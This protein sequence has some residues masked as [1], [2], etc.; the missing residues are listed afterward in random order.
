MPSQVTIVWRI[1]ARFGL[2]DLLGLM[3]KYNALVKPP[4]S[5][6]EIRVWQVDNLT[7]KY[8][9][10]S[11]VVQGNIN[12]YTKYLLQDIENIDGLIL[13]EKNAAKLARIF[14]ARQNA[15]IC[16]RC[17]ETSLL[18]QAE[19]KGLDIVF[20]K[21]CGHKNALKPP[22]MM[23]CA[24]I[25]PDINLL[26]SK[27]MSRLLRLGLLTDF[28]I[29]IPEFIFDWLDKFKST[30][31]K[32]AISDELKQL[33][34]LEQDGNVKLLPITTQILSQ[35]TLKDEDQVILAISMLTNSILL[36]GD[37]ILKDRALMQKRP[38]I[39]LPPKLFDQL[40]LLEAVR[41]PRV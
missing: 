37:K 12:D 13:D 11:L 17:R 40:K 22:L 24:R 14:P 7:V 6:H 25:L 39:Y 5:E 1:S 15:I 9:Q 18:I 8:Y 35:T 30:K 26:I 20:K 28:E 41:F 10:S 19:K 4:S 16:E 36:T 23:L 38:V 2:E 32:S 3:E 34:K 33:R 21:E 29:V 27:S 31:G